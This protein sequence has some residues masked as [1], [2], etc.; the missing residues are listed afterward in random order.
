MQHAQSEIRCCSIL[1][2]EVCV[3]SF[4]IKESLDG[5]NSS[6]S[7]EFFGESDGILPA[8]LGPISVQLI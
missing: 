6:T 4:S 8:K 5:N 3:L 7:A 2:D 1:S